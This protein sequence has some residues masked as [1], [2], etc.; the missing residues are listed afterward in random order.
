MRICMIAPHYYPAVNG[1]AVTVRRIERH[2]RLLGCE[3]QVFPVDRMTG[4][5][6][7]AGVRAF[8]PQML[9][10]FHAYHGGRMAH[11]LADELSIPYLVTLTGTDVYQALDDHRSFDTHAALRSASR[12]VAFHA[13]VK[14][15]LAEHL[16]SLEERTVVIPQGV[17]LP[18]LPVATGTVEGSCT[19]LLPA[20]LRPVKNVLFPLQPLAA[21]HAVHPGIR[22]LLVGPVL[23]PAYAGEVMEALE[24]YPF[25]RYLGV[26]GHDA[27]GDLYRAADVVLNSSLIEGG[28]ANSVLEGLAYGKPLLVTDIEGN[29]SI[30]RECANGLLYRDAGEFCRKAEM[31]VTDLVLRQKLGGN[32]RSLVRDKYPPERESQSYLELY[33]AILDSRNGPAT[34]E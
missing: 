19:F 29:R 33:Q 23:D 18:A 24:R 8:A 31:L 27:M 11:A 32:G 4:E 25:A 34:A 6:L 5:E 2:L 14:R 15:R 13:Y 28:M 17:E 10:A 12:L 26:V 9:H 20:G 21:L 7:L 1:N 16:P 22:F 3:V 30:V